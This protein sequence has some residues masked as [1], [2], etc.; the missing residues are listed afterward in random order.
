MIYDHYFDHKQQI[1][2]I[3]VIADAAMQVAN[4]LE[5]QNRLVEAFEYVQIA[6]EKYD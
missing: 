1:H 4:I 5:E 3:E 6:Y 2:N